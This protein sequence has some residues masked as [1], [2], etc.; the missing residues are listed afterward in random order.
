[1]WST[2]ARA[3]NYCIQLYGIRDVEIRDVIA[4]DGDDFGISIEQAKR[5]TI[6]GCHVHTFADDANSN[7]ITVSGAAAS[8]GNSATITGNVIENCGTIGIDIQSFENWVV[9]GNTVRACKYGIDIEG[10]TDPAGVAGNIVRSGL[11]SNNSVIGTTDTNDLGTTLDKIGIALWL[12]DTISSGDTDTLHYN[13]NVTGNTIKDY[14]SALIGFGGHTNISENNI[15]EYGN[16]GASTNGI[17]IGSMFGTTAKTNNWRIANNYFHQ[18]TRAA[19]GT[20]SAIAINN[21]TTDSIDNVIIDGNIINGQ[22]L[23]AGGSTQFGI[24]IATV[25]NN[26]RITNNY[27]R[28]TTN[29][30]IRMLTNNSADAPTPSNW[31]ISNNHMID[32]NNKTGGSASSY[33]TLSDG[34][35]FTWSNVRIANNVAYDAN[36]RMSAL[37]ST[38]GTGWTGALSV[39]GNVAPDVTTQAWGL[40]AAGDILYQANNFIQASPVGTLDNTGTPSVKGGTVFKTGGTATITDLD[41]GILGQRVTILLAHALDFT[42]SAALILAGAANFTTGAVGDTITFEMFNDQVWSEVARS[43]NT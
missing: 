25:G 26:W 43:I 18:T 40:A 20:V 13:I 19:S 10:N 42:H 29:Q 34:N 14:D 6:S 3:I 31:D 5:V 33:M 41:D 16:G 39:Y 7:G 21:S 27:F 37:F 1:L 30:P 8:I 15:Y 11:I 35:N 36:S 23:A 38:S 28:G 12:R 22:D 24:Y 4:R 9:T 32:C 17:L 2:Q